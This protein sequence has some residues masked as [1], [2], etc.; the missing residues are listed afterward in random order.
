MCYE[1]VPCEVSPFRLLLERMLSGSSPFVGVCC[2]DSGR[3]R[4]KILWQSKEGG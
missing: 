2:P 4:H 1:K 3:P